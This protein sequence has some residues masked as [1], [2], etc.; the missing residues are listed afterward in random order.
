MSLREIKNFICG[1]YSAAQSKK[2]IDNFNPSNGK[3]YST[4]PRSDAGDIE[5]AVQAAQKAFPAWSRTSPEER[6]QILLKI[7]EGIE[8]RIPQLAEAE[9]TDQGKPVW[10]AETLDIPRAAHNFR[11]FAGQILFP[12]NESHEFNEK[13]FNFSLRKPVGVAGLISPWNL[14][15]YLLTWKIAPALAC[16]NTV[17][18]KPSEITPM[19]AFLFCDILNEA[20][21]PPGVVNMVFGLGVEAG[22][23]LVK[24]PKVPLIS[25]TGGTTTGKHLSSAAAPLI[26][27]LSLELGGK[28]ANIIFADADL[29]EAIQTSLRSSFLNQGEICLCGSRIFVEASIYE[30]FVSRFVSETKKL[31]VGD[32]R[33]AEN[34]L[35]ALVSKA[36]LEKVQSYVKLAQDEG[37]KIE[38]GFEDIPLT[39]EQQQGYYMRPTIITGLRSECRVMQEEI[40]GPVVT[41]VPFGSE[42][43][44][45]SMA[46]SVE[47]GLAST[48]WTKDIQRVHRLARRLEVGTLWVNTWMM[49]DLR[50]PFGGMKMSGLGR[51][52]GL[53]SLEFFTE[54]TNVCIKY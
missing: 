30:S 25:F 22:E 47:Y 52:G 6:S 20:G 15:L 10:L 8:R 9:S 28:N 24:H 17:V 40:F 36:H 39:A 35:G 2:R 21:L 18:C 48:L 54:T 33:K 27:K 19:T 16:G 23:A 46:N 49:R 1:E 26:K 7:A 4:L 45:V 53:H 50:T 3:V 14:P 41:V 29:E 12:C 37:G 5:A 43:E 32:P 51:E 44:V 13:A 42:E 11:F 38:T 31:K 34:F